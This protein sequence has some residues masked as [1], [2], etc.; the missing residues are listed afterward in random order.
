MRLSCCP[1]LSTRGLVHMTAL[2]RL[3]MLEVEACNVKFHVGDSL[4]YQQGQESIRRE[5]FWLQSKVR[6]SN[7][8]EPFRCLPAARVAWLVCAPTCGH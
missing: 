1:G 3:T 4:D 5:D 6:C 2:T 8:S 7:S